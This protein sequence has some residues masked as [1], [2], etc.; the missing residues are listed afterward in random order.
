MYAT[1][2]LSYYRTVKSLCAI[3]PEILGNKDI[4]MKAEKCEFHCNR[5]VVL[6]GMVRRFG[7]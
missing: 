1:C 5:V 3:K 2:G 6:L 7:G 4:E